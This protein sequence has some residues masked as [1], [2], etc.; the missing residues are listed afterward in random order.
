MPPEV[1]LRSF[2]M[3]SAAPA[4][5]PEIRGRKPRFARAYHAAIEAFCTADYE[6][7][8]KLANALTQ[9]LNGGVHFTNAQLVFAPIEA[10]KPVFSKEKVALT[11]AQTRNFTLSVDIKLSN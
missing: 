4:G 1:T 10:I 11:A 2:K 6:Q 9:A 5:G 3:G 8:L 7:G